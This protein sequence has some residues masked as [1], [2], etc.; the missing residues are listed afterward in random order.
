MRSAAET[1]GLPIKD[2]LGIRLVSDVHPFLT[3]DPNV[4]AIQFRQEFEV[5]GG[6]EENGN[7]YESVKVAASGSCTYSIVSAN[8]SD[9]MA[10]TFDLLV[11]GVTHQIRGSY[12][13]ANFGGQI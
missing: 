6:Y 12:H 5:P 10:Y 3:E 11:G 8:I 13:V 4:Y 9:M 7:R 2:G 1:A